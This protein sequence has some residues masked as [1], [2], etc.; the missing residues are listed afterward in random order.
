MPPRAALVNQYV[1]SSSVTKSMNQPGSTSGWGF[2]AKIRAKVS[3]HMPQI[4]NGFSNPFL[5]SGPA[6]Q[7]HKE[8][9]RLDHES[10]EKSLERGKGRKEH[11]HCNKL[12]GA[13]KD[14]HGHQ[15]GIPKG[16]P[17]TLHIKSIGCSD[18][19]K[20]GRNGK[21]SCQG[22]PESISGGSKASV[23]PIFVLLVIDHVSCLLR[24]GLACNGFMSFI[25]P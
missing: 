18:K 10:H 25:M 4:R 23:F 11:G 8:V 20:S 7:C 3:S 6:W 22:L 13:A 15:H 9:P 14:D 5:Y 17:H 16:K 21:C 24:Y 1:Q 2:L 12:Q 19:K